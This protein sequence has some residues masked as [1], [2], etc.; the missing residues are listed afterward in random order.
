MFRNAIRSR[1][2]CPRADGPP[3]LH[4]RSASAET[5]GGRSM[6]FDAHPSTPTLSWKIWPLLAIALSVA[7]CALSDA[8][9]RKAKAGGEVAE[10]GKVRKVQ[11]NEPGGDKKVGTG[12]S[13]IGQTRVE[14]TPMPAAA[15]GWF[16]EQV[17][18]GED[19]W[20]PAVAVDP[21]NP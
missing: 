2:S 8:D 10:A 19:D 7:G 4:A 15:P 5:E 6:R 20:E 12:Q 1:S 9:A 21:G 13:F 16:S 14:V 17:A 18:S 3:V 11:P